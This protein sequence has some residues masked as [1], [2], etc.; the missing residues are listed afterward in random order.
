MAIDSNGVVVSG[1]KAAD[2]ASDRCPAALETSVLGNIRKTRVREI[3]VRAKLPNKKIVT[4]FSA[5]HRPVDC[6]VLKHQNS[7]QP[8]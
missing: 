5:I 1:G 3:R 7:L 2:P 4:A 6:L 8:Q